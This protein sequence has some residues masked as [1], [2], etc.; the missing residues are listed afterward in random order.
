[1]DAVYRSHRP[2]RLHR[3]GRRQVLLDLGFGGVAVAVLAGCTTGSS[4]SVATGT[5]SA[6]AGSTT[7]G[8]TTAGSTTA[9]S[10][11]AAGPDP[12][13]ELSWKRV[14]LGFVSAYVVLR[15][16][17]AAVVDTGVAGSAD[18]IGT[19]LQAAGTSWDEVSDVIL[20]H[21]HGDHA[22]SL[23]EVVTRAARAA[24]HAGEADISRVT[25]PRPIV[26]A[27]DGSDVLGLQVV[28]TPGHTEG[29]ISVFDRGT[30]VLIAGDALN[31]SAGL[32][33]SSPR[34]TADPAKAAESVK[35]MAALD[36][37]TILFGHG[38]PLTSGA[39]DALRTYA[40]TL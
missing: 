32:T 6:T 5:G 24:V 11:T 38:E 17:R 2:V 39:A 27:P 10:T 3:L 4:G 34:N 23:G 29:H 25:S 20:T 37:G 15:G 22:G 7:A 40:G 36:V 26:P 35:K 12:T 1:M 33:G 9:G 28:A 8:S 16:G 18:A 21:H 19:A 30:R 31:N 14:E 13:G